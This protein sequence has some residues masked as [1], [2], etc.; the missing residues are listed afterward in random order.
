MAKHMLLV[1]TNAADGKDDEFNRWYNEVHLVDVLAVD[2]FVAA[3][4][5]ALKDMSG[6]ASP[7]RYLAIYEVETDDIDGVVERFDQ[8]FP[9]IGNRINRSRTDDVRSLRQF[10]IERCP[11]IAY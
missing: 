5:F 1:F 2:G 7:H 11:A 9:R 10:Q 8:S 3:Q 6:S 4:R